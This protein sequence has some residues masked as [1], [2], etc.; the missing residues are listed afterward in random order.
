MRGKEY[1]SINLL[2][3]EQE[4]INI[5]IGLVILIQVALVISIFFIAD[6]IGSIKN[7]V[8]KSEQFLTSEF[9]K[10]VFL[11]KKEKAI[12]ILEELIWRDFDLG[13]RG[14]RDDEFRVQKVKFLKESFKSKMEQVNYTWPETLK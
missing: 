7:R 9:W 3:M 13:I 1:N 12:E 11:G 14:M 5:I 2:V 10:H 6:A 8:K 4:T